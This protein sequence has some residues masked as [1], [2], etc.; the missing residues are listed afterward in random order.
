MKKARNANP[1]TN[2]KT[3]GLLIGRLG[4]V[5]YAAQVWPGIAAVAEERDVNL[6]CFMGGALR[7]A[8]EFES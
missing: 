3:I 2:R 4:D 7:A 1:R 8:H 6:I 5:G